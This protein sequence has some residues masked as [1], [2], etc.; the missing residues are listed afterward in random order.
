MKLH[1][2]KLK[3]FRQ[4]YGSSPKIEFAHGEKNVTV[5]HGYNGS[6]KTA[7][8]NAF[9][10]LLYGE[11]SAGFQQTDHLVNKRA[12]R[13]ASVGEMVEAEV[14]LKFEHIG[15]QYIV[16][17]RFQ[18][19]KG[20]ASSSS[21]SVTIGP[22]MQWCDT[23]G[24]WKV[25]NR[26]GEVIGRILPRDLHFYF[27]FDGERIEKFF[28]PTKEEKGDTADALKQFLGIEPLERAERHLLTT[29]RYFQEELKRIGDSETKGILEKREYAE[30][31]L[32]K[33][34]NHYSNVEENIAVEKEHRNR[35]EELLRKNKSAAQLQARRD[36]LEN[37]RVSTRKAKDDLKKDLSYSI[38]SKGYSIFLPKVAEKY[39]QLEK[40]LRQAGE[41][42]SGIKKQF[43]QE[44]LSQ[45][46]CICGAELPQN[47]N[48]RKTLEE[49]LDRAGLAEV[50]ERLLKLG[51]RLS[52]L[53]SGQVK[54]FYRSTNDLL[55][56]LERN[57]ID[58]S[59][60]EN[61][62]DSVHKELGDSPEV[63]IRNIEM[64]KRKADDAITDYGLEL[65]GTKRDIE[66]I[67]AEIRQLD[68]ELEKKREKRFE[69][70]LAKK[71]MHAAID[72]QATIKRMRISMEFNNVRAIDMKLKKRFKEM[73][74]HL[75][76][77][78]QLTENFSIELI[79]SA[80]GEP[81]PVAASQGEWQL[82]SFAFLAT[83]I[84]NAREW[85][86]KKNSIQRL[87]SSKF[88]IVMDS[89]FG[90]LDPYYRTQV[91]EQLPSLADQVIILVTMTQWRGEVENSLA[92]KIGNQYVLEYHS[93]EENIPNEVI[94][95]GNQSYPLIKKSPNEY[96]Y[97][98][99]VEVRNG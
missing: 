50:E 38:S 28:N 81:M 57:R 79:E 27:F 24:N 39:F 51:G 68:K 53:G 36:K 82:V 10:W 41:L 91:A 76:Y 49:W 86:K 96:E 45:E 44:L 31:N 98:E 88:P 61:D 47:S 43:V 95:F 9:T 78:P 21:R 72:A 77:I 84:E 71:R 93:P 89:P 8:L 75:P 26:P 46:K 67:E 18:Q 33:Q 15:K 12:I 54:D 11:F 22:E 66:R 70:E 74:P 7:L 99:I 32:I 64:R 16:V 25:E 85:Q 62:L 20:E 80:G 2:L 94:N 23:D 19:K 17:R 90:S 13:E 56:R 52:I 59:T 37:Q 48:Q 55:A 29:V 58:L 40:S 73:A 34:K 35:I 92:G 65:G 30:Q 14:K 63:Q 87:D 3:N 5:I 69:C 97:T 1:W 60:I 6:G 83:I 4:F 42:P